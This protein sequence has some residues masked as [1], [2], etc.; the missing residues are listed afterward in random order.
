MKTLGESSKVIKALIMEFQEML[1]KVNPYVKDFKAICD[2]PA[3]LIK[4]VKFVLRP[5]KAQ[6]GHKGQFNLPSTNEVAIIALNEITNFMDIEVH[7]KSGGVQYISEKSPHADPLHFVLLFPE[8]THGWTEGLL[9]TNGQKLT[10]QL[11]YKYLLQCR[12]EDENHFNT[13]LRSGR[14]MQEYACSAFYKIERD[15]LNYVEKDAFQK[16]RVKV[17]SRQNIIDAMNA[18]EDTGKI[19]NG[20]GKH[21][22][23]PASHVGSPRWYQ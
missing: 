6:R 11:F 19:D 4:D 21:I 2:I 9:Q 23:L 8:G 22:V 7:L 3:D 12:K 18:N 5:D 1:K 20:I 15:R 10:L 13:I 17:A 16:N 14:L